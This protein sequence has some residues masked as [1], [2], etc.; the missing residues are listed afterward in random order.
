MQVLDETGEPMPEAWLRVERAYPPE[1]VQLPDQ[2]VPLLDQI[3]WHGPTDEAGR[4]SIAD[5]PTGWLLYV[6]ALGELRSEAR[7]VV[8]AP[9]AR[10]QE[11]TLLAER[12]GSLSGT[13][14][15]SDESPVAG[16]AVRHRINRWTSRFGGFARTD[17]G[18]RFLIRDVAAGRGILTVGD[19]RAPLRNHSIEV[20][21]VAG[22]RVDV[23]PI[24]LPALLPVSGRIVSDAT[25]D[26]EGYT[27]NVLRRD[28]ASFTGYV[29]FRADGSF[30]ISITPGHAVLR[31]LFKDQEWGAAYPI[32]GRSR[33]ATMRGAR[34]PRARDH[35]CPARAAAG[36]DPRA[37]PGS[38]AS[39]CACTRATTKRDGNHRAWVRQGCTGS[40]SGAGAFEG[41]FLPGRYA[42]EVQIDEQTRAWVPFRRDRG[43]KRHRPGRAP[44]GQGPRSEGACSTSRVSPRR[45]PGSC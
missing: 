10:S 1:G 3:V 16:V 2:S 31:V 4:F 8:L 23:G 18:G 37:G 17:E 39:T 43:G 7:E 27:W 15:D 21:V 19:G 12:P 26:F 29:P 45:K 32:A 11:L 24:L 41:V 14:L 13:V 35:R 6:T 36:R 33:G 28:G 20:D 9:G 40:R 38:S 42:V 30:A 5:L 34:D 22:G 44:A 25:D